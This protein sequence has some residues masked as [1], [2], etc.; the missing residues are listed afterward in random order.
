MRHWGLC[1]PRAIHNTF[2]PFWHLAFFLPTGQIP[3]WLQGTLLRNGPGMHTV[4]E[5][6]YNHW[7]DGLALLHSFAIRDGESAGWVY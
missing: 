4:G 7:F 3:P 6:T 2:F 1:S 5:S